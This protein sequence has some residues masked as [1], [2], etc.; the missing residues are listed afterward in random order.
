MYRARGSGN[1]YTYNPAQDWSVWV[2]SDNRSNQGDRGTY[3]ER[4]GA[5]VGQKAIKTSTSIKGGVRPY[6]V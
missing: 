2:G 1:T 4:R 3:T 6:Q 5:L